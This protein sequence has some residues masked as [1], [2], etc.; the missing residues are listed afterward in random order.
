MLNPGS[1]FRGSPIQNNKLGKGGSVRASYP[2]NGRGGGK[3]RSGMMPLAP[4]TR[5]ARRGRTTLR[6]V[7]GHGKP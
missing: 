7:V 3:P 1:T 6:P 2:A 5:K 4:R